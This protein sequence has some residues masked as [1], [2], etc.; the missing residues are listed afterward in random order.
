MHHVSLTPTDIRRGPCMELVVTSDGNFTSR[1]L[2]NLLRSGR[3]SYSDPRDRSCC[4][5]TRIPPT[6]APRTAPIASGTPKTASHGTCPVPLEA[7][8]S[9]APPPQRA[10]TPAAIRTVRTTLLLFRAPLS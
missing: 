3:G 9:P 7:I 10:P 4:T 2:N 8:I 6:S 1:R 5:A